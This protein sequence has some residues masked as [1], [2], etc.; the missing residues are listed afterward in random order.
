MGLHTR[1]SFLLTLHITIAAA[2]SNGCEAP[3]S[4]EIT[5]NTV[6]G[7][8]GKGGEGKGGEGNLQSVAH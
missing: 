4:W 1:I 6:K 8:E 7:E 2:S 3:Q 5:I